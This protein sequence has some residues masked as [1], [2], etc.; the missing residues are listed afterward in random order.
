MVEEGAQHLVELVARLRR[1][2]NLGYVPTMRQGDTGVGF[3][4][5]ALLGIEA[6]SSKAPDF[7]GIEIKCSRISPTGRH[8]GQ[9]QTLFSLVPT[10]DAAATDRGDLVRRFGY[11]DKQ[12]SRQ[13]LYCTVTNAANSLGWSLIEDEVTSRILVAKNGLHVASYPY[14]EVRSALE[15]KH[16]FT[17]FV[18]AQTEV[19]S[20]VE[21][22]HF[23]T[24]AV[25]RKATM[26]RFLALQRT[27]KLGLDFA[28]HL[29]AD[30]TARD[31]GF[32]WRLGDKADLP[33]LFETFE[34]I[35]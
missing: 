13:S 28:I 29:R 21:H 8:R 9:K 12:R 22:F 33:H 7:F 20:G 17:M 5:E 27:G 4:L 35:A 30:G 14:E 34:S 2:R 11:I 25:A 32:L 23:D 18:G 15:K 6:N 10:W 3:T 26:G 19:V 24:F 31:H 16:R 1:I